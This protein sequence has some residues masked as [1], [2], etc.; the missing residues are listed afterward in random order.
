MMVQLGRNKKLPPQNNTR[1]ARKERPWCIN[2]DVQMEVIFETN[3]FKQS[4]M[5]LK[6]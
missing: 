3:N 5:E 1:S 2:E 4:T 6:L